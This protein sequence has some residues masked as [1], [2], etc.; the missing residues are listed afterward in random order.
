MEVNTT[1]IY[2]VIS[3][4][5][6]AILLELF[7][8]QEVDRFRQKMFELRD[9]LFLEAANGLVGFDHPAYG[10][11]RTT[12]NGFIRFAHRVSIWHAVIG[13]VLAPDRGG[14]AVAAWKKKQR[15]L[16]PHQ[17]ERLDYY[18]FRMNVLIL[19][20][21]L[22]A[23]PDMLFVWTILI[24]TFIWSLVNSVRKG[25]AK[26]VFE[27]AKRETATRLSENSGTEELTR[28]ALAYDGY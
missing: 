15:N 5:G 26:R 22:L 10:Y 20:H 19:E 3:L 2:S 1:P 18:R 6:L 28:L 21:F 23:L 14:E 12:M 25:N 9:K 8:R 7:R 11:L 16:S 4:V 24:L 13:F 27:A 17:R